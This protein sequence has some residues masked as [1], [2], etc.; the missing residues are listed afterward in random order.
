M[1]RPQLDN[2]ETKRCADCG[3]VKSVSEFSRFSKLLTS[4]ERKRFCLS[5]CKP[6][7]ADRNRKRYGEEK[8]ERQAYQ[9]ALTAR[10]KKRAMDGY[11]G[12][13]AC[14][15]EDEIDFLCIDHVNGDGKKHRQEMGTSGGV[16][17]YRLVVKQG[18]PDRFQILCFN[19]NNA[20]HQ[21]GVCPHQLKVGSLK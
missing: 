17:L 12:C 13:C 5:Y 11:G 18:F 7:V 15:G 2:G 21:R 20:K 9:R 6:C 14:C 1:G 19:C 3:V 8:E 10:W 4:G 16:T